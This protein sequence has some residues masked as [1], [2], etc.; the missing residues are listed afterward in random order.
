ML[1]MSTAC[2]FHTGGTSCQQSIFSIESSCTDITVYNLNT[3]G[4]ASMVD[5]DGTSLAKY[6]DNI[7]VFPDTIALFRL[8]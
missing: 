8:W 7:D 6:S 1:I 4:A 3:V 5:R 2:A